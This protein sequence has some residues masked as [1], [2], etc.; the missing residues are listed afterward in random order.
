MAKT[1]S[2]TGFAAARNNNVMIDDETHRPLSPES[3][4]YPI[5]NKANQHR[6]LSPQERI[7]S[8]ITFYPKSPSGPTSSYHQSPR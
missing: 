2:A 1:M 8:P 4:N 7:R 6:L 3:E 5:L